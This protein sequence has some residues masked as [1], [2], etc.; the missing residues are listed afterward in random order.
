MEF[1]ATIFFIAL[2]WYAYKSWIKA[3]VARGS[4]RKRSTPE[5]VFEWPDTG[6]YD[7]EIVGESYYQETIKGLAGQNDM[8]VSE[9]EYQAL[10]I[11]DDGNEH[12]DKAVRVE[13]GG[14]TVGHLSRENA[15]SFRR[16]LRAKKLT[17]QIT[18]CKAIVRG[19]GVRDG[20]KWHYG[21]ALNIKEFSW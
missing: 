1:V 10:L 7:F 12:D 21:V 9:R 6:D 17:G 14:M 3:S 20:E 16:R 2:C 11:P 4:T 18:T 15:R 8:Y 19:G 13:I 5:H